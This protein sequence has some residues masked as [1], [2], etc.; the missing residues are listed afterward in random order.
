[1]S[2]VDALKCLLSQILSLSQKACIM[3]AYSCQKT[4]YLNF[5]LNFSKAPG[6]IE[7]FSFMYH[8]HAHS[9]ASVSRVAK[10]TWRYNMVKSIRAHFVLYVST[11]KRIMCVQ[12]NFELYYL[13]QKSK[14]SFTKI[15]RSFLC[16]KDEATMKNCKP[17]PM[18]SKN[19]AFC[20]IRVAFATPSL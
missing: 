19:L 20:C 10:L 8:M 14:L 2:Q 6:V 5:S 4:I 18:S 13:L 11:I 3:S 1:M 9:Q 7:M 16:W 12:E 17:T 15:F